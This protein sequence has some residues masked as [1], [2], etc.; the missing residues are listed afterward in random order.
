M[1][2][3]GA[4]HSPLCDASKRGRAGGEQAAVAARQVQVDAVAVLLL[5]RER[6]GRGTQ[7]VSFE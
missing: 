6:G 1:R 5:R 3:R 4:R 7:G 2:R